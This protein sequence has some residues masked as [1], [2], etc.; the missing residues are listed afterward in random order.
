[1]TTRKLLTTFT[2]VLVIFKTNG[3]TPKHYFKV[4]DSIVLAETTSK[5]LQTKLDT[6]KSKYIPSRSSFSLSFDRDIDF[7]F[8]HHRLT[9]ELNFER[10]QIDLLTRNDTIYARTIRHYYNP[11][12]MDKTTLA[13]D[14]SFS[15]EK[16]NEYLT[17]RNK[18]YKSQKTLKDLIREMSEYRVFA[19]YCGDGSPLT[20]EGKQIKEIAA[21]GK[22][23]TLFQMLQSIC[24]ETQAYG[25]SGFKILETNGYPIASDVSKIIKRIKK[26]N[27]ETVTCSGCITGLIRKIYS[28][29]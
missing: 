25:V 24:V 1:M 26:R 9:V 15:F 16:V 23:D 2:L 14:S 28:K 6:L 21:E 19:F 5:Y 27:S 29:K 8:R 3:Q 22:T 18:F 20:E 12:E 17:Q 4:V 7:V 11:F 13:F 10:F